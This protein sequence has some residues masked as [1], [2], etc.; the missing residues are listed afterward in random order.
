MIDELVRHAVEVTVDLDVVVDADPARFPLG[1]DVATGRQRPERRPVEQPTRV[2]ARPAADAEL[3]QGAVVQVAEPGQMAAF[4]AARL[5]K[6]WSRS[7]ARIHRCATSTA[8]STTALSF[9]LPGR[10]GTTT[11][12]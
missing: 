5:K 1:Q 10:A 12:S 6:V 3:L 11:A 8:D 7:R 9:G 2:V 4:S